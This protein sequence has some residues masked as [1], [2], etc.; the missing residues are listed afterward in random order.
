MDPYIGKTK[1]EGD[2]IHLWG[3]WKQLVSPVLAAC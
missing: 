1:L 2:Y 3:N